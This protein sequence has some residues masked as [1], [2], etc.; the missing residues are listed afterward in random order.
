MP[1]NQNYVDICD[2]NDKFRCYSWG[3]TYKDGKACYDHTR[4]CTGKLECVK[5]WH[6]VCELEIVRESQYYS[7][8]EN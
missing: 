6:E 5:M 8:S 1:V 4:K 7:A 3:E 2:S